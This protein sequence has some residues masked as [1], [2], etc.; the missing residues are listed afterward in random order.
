MPRRARTRLYRGP[1]TALRDSTSRT[2]ELGAELRKIR[3]AARYTGRELA[4]KLGWD[5]SKIS[6]MESGDRAFSE[7]DAAVY[8]AFCGAMG[9]Q[10]K[11]VLDLARKVDDNYWLH[12]RGERIPDELKSLIVQENTAQFLVKYDPLVVPGLTQTEDY[13]RALFKECAMVSKEGLEL[14]V[15]IR[16][17]RQRLLARERPPEVTFYIHENALRTKVG[18]WPVM[19]EQLLHLLLISSTP[20]CRMRVLPASRGARAAAC[21]PFTWMAHREHNPVIY[22][23]HLTT[24]L[25]LETREDAILYRR[26]IDRLTAHAL[27]EGQSRECAP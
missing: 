2:R 11:Q 21:G 22:T 12:I 9:D 13:A 4:K 17:D 5:Q 6:R 1:M 25:F 15:Q 3:E 26:I 23:E 27:D 24:S 18:T 10:L 20:H 7:V 19:H 16:M 8:A 14:R